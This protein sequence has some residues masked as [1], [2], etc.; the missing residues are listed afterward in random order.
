MSYHV[1]YHPD[2]KKDVSDFPQNIKSRLKKAIETRLMSDP[3]R[4]GELLKKTL[5][6]FRKL[7]VGDYRIIYKISGKMVTILKIGHRKEVYKKSRDF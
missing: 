3:V 7:R 6:G 1:V 4:Y 2:V 5:K